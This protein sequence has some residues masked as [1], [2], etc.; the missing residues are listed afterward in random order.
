MIANE[1]Y[2]ASQNSRSLSVDKLTAELLLLT[3]AEYSDGCIYP[4]SDTGQLGMTRGEAVDFADKYK[5]TIIKAREV[6]SLCICCGGDLNGPHYGAG[7]GTGQKFQ[8]ERC[9]D[10]K[11]GFQ[12]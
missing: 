12:L 3:Y 10:N 5:D 4:R 9:H 2:V 7:D 6:M 1:S 8:C 11:S